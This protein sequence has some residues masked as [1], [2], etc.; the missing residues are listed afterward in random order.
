M[1]QRQRRRSRRPHEL[2]RRKKRR[3]VYLGKRVP[4]IGKPGLDTITEVE[5]I[6]KA[7][8][9]DVQK[10]RIPY[11]TAMRRLNGLSLA[12]RRSKKFPE[13]RK[14]KALQVIDTYRLKLERW[15]E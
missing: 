15:G 10:H 11:V 8:L 12:V 1:A 9:E 5:G 7:I 3:N 2:S 6:S 13:S 4:D 14:G